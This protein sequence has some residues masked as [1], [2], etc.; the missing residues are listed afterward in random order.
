MLTGRKSLAKTSGQPG[1]TQLINHFIIEKS[2]YLADL[3][4]YGFAKVSKKMR[5]EFDKMIRSYC[6]NRENLINLFVLVD[7]RHEPLKN[8]IEFMKWL[9]ENGLPF[10]IVLTKIDKLNP[11]KLRSNRSAYENNF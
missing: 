1:K 8:D 6:A 2:W 10:S 3:P 7:S 9:S 5:G 11:T 4:G